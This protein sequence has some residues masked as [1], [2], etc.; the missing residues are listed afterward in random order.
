M[1]RTILAALMIASPA[2]ASTYV[3][4][5]VDNDAVSWSG[6]VDTDADTLTV[7]S[8]VPVVDSG[9]N[10]PTL[11][12]VWPARRII[13]FPNHEQGRAWDA[14]G[15]EPADIDGNWTEG[16]FF[17]AGPVADWPLAVIGGWGGGYGNDQG[18]RLFGGG[19]GLTWGRRPGP[20]GN[21]SPYQSWP[22]TLTVT[23]QAVPEPSSLLIFGLLSLGLLRY[24]TRA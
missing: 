5:Y 3:V 12:A 21:T 14:Y 22:D 15:A 8:F 18:G 6:V 17:D 16:I 19:I 10:A 1:K 24:R 2:A 13:Y 9:L 7:T 11:P 23:P 4:D 20:I